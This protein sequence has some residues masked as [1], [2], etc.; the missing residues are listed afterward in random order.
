MQVR[1]IM[2]GNGS[3]RY[4]D[5]VPMACGKEKALQYERQ[6]YGGPEHLCVAARDSGNDVLMLEREHPGEGAG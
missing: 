4:V 2:S 5:C 6:L 3:H 1:I